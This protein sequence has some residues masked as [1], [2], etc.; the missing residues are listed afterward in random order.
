MSS[1]EHLY[2]RAHRVNSLHTTFWK[3]LEQ[4]LYSQNMSPSIYAV[5]LTA[6]TYSVTTYSV[7]STYLV[8]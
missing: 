5:I 8:F 4:A 6:T 7:V 1:F 3:Q 2:M